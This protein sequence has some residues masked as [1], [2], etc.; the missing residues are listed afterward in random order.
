MSSQELNNV[1]DPSTPTNKSTKQTKYHYVMRKQLKLSDEYAGADVKKE[2]N[3]LHIKEIEPLVNK[4]KK[5]ANN[6]QDVNDF[7]K[8][9][10][11]EK[12]KAG[13]ITDFQT[14]KNVLDVIM[15]VVVYMIPE[16]QENSG[17]GFVS[18]Y[19]NF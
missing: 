11:I 19:L 16:L 14:N 18:L 9:F 12:Q 13:K 15:S 7:I 2:D 5:E 6:Q 3:T 4:I 8:E 17:I 10:I 1:N